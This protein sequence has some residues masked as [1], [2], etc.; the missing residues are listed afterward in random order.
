MQ[1]L[2]ISDSHGRIDR[3]RAALDRTPDCKNV[4]YLG[5]GISDV[6]AVAPSFPDRIFRCVRGNMDAPS[7]GST[8]R[9]NRFLHPLRQHRNDDARSPIRREERY[10]RRRGICRAEGGA[11]TS[12]RAYPCAGGSVFAGRG[13]IGLQPRQHRASGGRGAAFWGAFAPARRRRAFF[14]RYTFTLEFPL[15]PLL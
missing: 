8:G 10:R 5:D 3:L 11:G 4:L 2:V 9:G 15:T 12:F 1:F 14:T 6:A 7:L 13:D